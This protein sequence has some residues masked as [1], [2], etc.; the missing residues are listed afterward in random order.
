MSGP[1]RTILAGGIYVGTE[2]VAAKVEVAAE[3]KLFARVLLATAERYAALRS[4]TQETDAVDI[5]DLALQMA[6]AKR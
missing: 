2:E 3:P 5:L 6:R 1:L 4:Q